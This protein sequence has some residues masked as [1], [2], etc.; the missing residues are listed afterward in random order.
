MLKWSAIIVVLALIIILGCKGGG[1]PVI[2]PDGNSHAAITGPY[3]DPREVT[4][5]CLECHGDVAAD[6]MQTSHWTWVSG[7][8]TLPG[9]SAPEPYGKINSIN[10][11]CISVPSNWGR[12]TQCHIGYGWNS[13]EF[14]FSDEMNLDCLICHD[15]T[16]TYRKAKTTAGLPEESVDLE[17]VAQNVGTPSRANCGACHFNGGGGNAV[18]HG[19]LDQSMVNP[20]AS[21]DIHMG[22][23]DMLCQDCHVTRD[24]DIGG[25]LPWLNDYISLD[26]ECTSCHSETPHESARLNWHYLSVSCQTCHIPL[27]AYEDPTVMHWDWSTAGLPAAPDDREWD[28]KKGSF[29]KATDVVPEYFWFNGTMDSYLPGDEMDPAGE[30]DLNYPLGDIDDPGAKIWPFKVHRGYQPYD[31]SYNIFLIPKLFGPGGFWATFNWDPA[32][33]L[34]AEDAGIPYSGNYG[35]ADSAM[36][37]PIT[38]MVQSTENALQ[39]GACHTGEDPGLLDWEAMGYE[40]DPTIFGSRWD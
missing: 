10:N 22:G 21:I 34:G 9:G 31:T 1:T 3:D 38:H 4:A 23:A 25:R 5:Q 27:Y 39:C 8:V 14:D 35:F 36:Y 24:H 37:W 7:E 32:F 33:Q 16:G 18:K 40:G 26:V 19:D 6:I 11:F 30:T 17:Y 13:P 2:P 12:C 28:Q 20:S 15:T 29:V